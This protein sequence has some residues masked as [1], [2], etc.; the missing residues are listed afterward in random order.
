VR[1]HLANDV[2]AARRSGQDESDRGL[3]STSICHRPTWRHAV[4]ACRVD[5]SAR[6]DRWGSFLGPPKGWRRSGSGIDEDLRRVALANTGFGAWPCPKNKPTATSTAP[7]IWCHDDRQVRAIKRQGAQGRTRRQLLVHRWRPFASPLCDKVQLVKVPHQIRHRH[8]N[9]TGKFPR[10]Q[11][12][13]YQMANLHRLFNCFDMSVRVR[14]SRLDA[15]ER[16]KCLAL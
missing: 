10:Q 7:T 6:Q 12:F 14:R 5:H 9:K 2:L 13:I 11:T 16:L 4:R 1:R 3:S 8:R 15:V